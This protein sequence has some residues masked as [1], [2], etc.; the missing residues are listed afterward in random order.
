M[1]KS[2]TRITAIAIISFFLFSCGDGKTVEQ[3]VA[4]AEAKTNP[5]TTTKQDKPSPITR[6]IKFGTKSLEYT[7]SY[8]FSLNQ[9]RSKNMMSVNPDLIETAYY[10]LLTPPSATVGLSYQKLKGTTNLDGAVNGILEG[11][12]RIEGV[13]ITGQKIEDVSS[14]YGFPARMASGT[15]QIINKN[16]GTDAGEFKNLLIDNKNEMWIIQG[17]FESIGSVESIAY[18]DILNSIK[19]N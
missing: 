19:I 16:G 1:K 2:I 7:G 6:V 5:K 4:D 3:K 14:K 9:E 10:R 11:Y 12:N 8:L 17:I 18:N 15:M 13:K